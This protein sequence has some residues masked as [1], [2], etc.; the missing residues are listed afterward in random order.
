[1]NLG[2]IAT[3]QHEKHEEYL[4][5]LFSILR[6][7]DEVVIVDKKTFF[8]KTELRLIGEIISAK[9]EGKRFISTQLA[10]RLGITRSA[11]SQIVSRL[12][13]RG[14]VKRV[15]DETDKKIAFIELS[16]NIEKRYLEDIAQNLAFIGEVVAE[17]GEEKFNQM[18][19]LFDAFIELA[20]KR[21]KETRQNGK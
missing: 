7:R 18:Y 9:T 12:E 10:K 21:L 15:P 6:K 13:K 4:A 11:I 19:E 17:F 1:M 3:L 5:K 16:K 2:K 20:K 8:N 14:V